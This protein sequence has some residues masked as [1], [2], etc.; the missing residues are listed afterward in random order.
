MKIGIISTVG[1]GYSWAGSEEMW[2]LLAESALAEGHDVRVNIA[3]SMAHSNELEH[4]KSLGG[5]VK[6]RADLTGITRRMAQRNLY[7]RFSDSLTKNEDIVVLSMGGV[8]DCLWIPDLL[9]SYWESKVPWVIIVQ[10][11]GEHII[12]KESER[13]ILRQFYARAKSVIFVSNHNLLLA[14]RQLAYRFLNAQVVVNPVRDSISE[15][16]LW[17]K[18]ENGVWNLAEVARFEVFQKRQDQLLE[19][20]STP[21]WTDRAWK[22]TFYGSGPDQQHI[23]SLV[24][25][26]GLEDKVHLGGYLKSIKDIW[27]DNHIHILPTAYEGVPL[28]LIESMF[29]GRPALVTRAGGNAEV[30]RDG[31]DGY[32]SPGMHPEII[33][34][35]LER[36]WADRERWSLM[37]LNAFDRVRGLVPRNWASKMLDLVKDAATSKR[38]S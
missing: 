6:G 13:E 25:L 23:L 24:K 28:S 22:L 17:P 8:A 7:S 36:A 21:E 29:C 15:P 2:R 27:K 20:L 32:V 18:S 37:G 11:N 38:E 5:F 33:R 3:S 9:S 10:S 4:L 19:A 14:E 12:S 34:E 35:T 31:I 1:G 30:V 26:Y 16:L